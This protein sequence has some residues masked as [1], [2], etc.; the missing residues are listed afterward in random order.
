MEGIT[1]NYRFD[2][3]SMGSMGKEDGTVNIPSI[4]DYF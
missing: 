3:I 4:M 2:G 1:E